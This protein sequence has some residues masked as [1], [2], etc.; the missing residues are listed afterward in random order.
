LSRYEK[1]VVKNGKRYLVSCGYDFPL[2]EYFLH[3]EYQDPKDI[4]ESMLDDE[5]PELL[6]AISS[7]S[8]L[9]CHPRYPAKTHFVN[10]EIWTLME[11][12]DADP[13]HIKAVRD[14]LPY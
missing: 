13:A 3:V 11:E 1:T 9:K 4:P 7:H 10:S 6:F 14:D 5:Q 2:M 8:T 12:W